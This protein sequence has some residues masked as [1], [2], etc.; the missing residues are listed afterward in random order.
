[1]DKII[2]RG[3][4]VDCVIGT[5]PDERTSPQTLFFDL[6]LYGDFSRAGETDELAD[7]VDYTAV[8]RC[9][10]EFAA[11]TSFFLLERLA[12]A[13]ARKLLEQFPLLN[14]ITLT[15]RKPSARVE[16]ES[17]AL[18]ITLARSYCVC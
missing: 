6:D 12:Y 16:S 1:M 3:L 4:P 8:E 14:R 7:A 18:E 11:G 10:K 15:V 9:V 2:L 5:F 17:V 13:S